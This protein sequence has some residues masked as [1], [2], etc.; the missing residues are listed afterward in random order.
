MAGPPTPITL[1]VGHC[2][3]EPIEFGGRIW[4]VMNEDQFGTGDGAIP[5]R[6][7]GSG[8][9]WQTGDVVSYL[10][11]GGTRLT[12]VPEGDAWAPGSACR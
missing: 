6:F 11:A 7:T 5:G 9:A 3:I 8:T 12:L 1:V 4:Q 10:D 2:W